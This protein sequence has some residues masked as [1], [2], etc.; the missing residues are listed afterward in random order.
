MRLSQA[1]VGQLLSLVSCNFCT[2]QTSETAALIKAKD[3]AEHSGSVGG[4]LDWGSNGCLFKN[5]YQ[6]THCVVFLSKT[7]NLL[8]STGSIQEDSKSS[9]HD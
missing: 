1:G 5:H 6:Q 3:F 2:I 9:R 8:L 4:A 7:L